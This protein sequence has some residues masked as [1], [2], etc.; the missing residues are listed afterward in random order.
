MSPFDR[1]EPQPSS[2]EPAS[3]I[4]MSEAR[5]TPLADGALWWADRRVLVVSDLHLEKASHFAARGALLPP[6]DTIETL[7]RLT[8]AI[9]RTAPAMVIALGDSFH[10]AQGPA[11]IGRRERDLLTDLTRRV[12]WVWVTGNHDA[13]AA[14]PGGSVLEELLL[15]PLTFRHEARPDASSGEISGHYHPKASLIRRGRRLSGRC[16]VSDARRLI[17]PAYGAFTGGLDVL[18]P[19]LTRLF[20]TDMRVHLIG[21]R[22]VHAFPIDLMISG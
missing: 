5:L 17:L 13:D 3:A 7:M 12:D 21:R 2:V 19:A 8:R 4:V 9:E 22:G 10:D 18:D 1:P 15:A 11:R 6:Y 16:F 20:G 14:L